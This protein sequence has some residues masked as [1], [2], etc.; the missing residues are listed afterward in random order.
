MKITAMFFLFSLSI[1]LGQTLSERVQYTCNR[2]SF[3]IATWAQIH[4]WTIHLNHTTRLSMKMFAMIFLSNRQSGR[5]LHAWPKKNTH[6]HTYMD[7][8]KNLHSLVRCLCTSRIL[9]KKK[10]P[11]IDMNRTL[12]EA[13]L[14]SVCTIQVYRII[15]GVYNGWR[16]EATKQRCYLRMRWN[17]WC[18]RDHYC[19]CYVFGVS[20]QVS[21]R[22]CSVFL[23]NKSAF[24]EGTVT[25][26]HYIWL[27]V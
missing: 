1:A 17:R 13:L 5:V 18:E 27:C 20:Q 19:F 2:I 14:C 23:T 24:D 12:S 4:N 11:H 3:G 25:M 7:S 26:L 22:N 21:R 6:T 10:S 8:R 15:K 9:R 16:I